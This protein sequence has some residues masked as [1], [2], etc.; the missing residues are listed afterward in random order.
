M[1][2]CS[3]IVSALVV[4]GLVGSAPRLHATPTLYSYDDTS[5]PGMAGSGVFKLEVGDPLGQYDA[6]DVA[7]GGT[8]FGT[9]GAVSFLASP[10][11]FASLTISNLAGG[12]IGISLPGVGGAEIQ[13]GSTATDEWSHFLG[14]SRTLGYRITA[15]TATVP[16]GG[17]TL[18]AMGCG[19]SA[20]LLLRRRV[21]AR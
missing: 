10:G 2:T 20:L 17:S 18:V 6:T 16:D 11:S 13:P 21:L 9:W 3:R 14:L 5:S 8:L 1:K 12:S 7:G 4:A 19:M 15:I